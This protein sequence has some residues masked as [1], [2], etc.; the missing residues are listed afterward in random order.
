MTRSSILFLGKKKL[1][2]SA[3]RWDSNEKLSEAVNADAL[4]IG[5]CGLPYIK[6]NKA[7]AIADSGPAVRPTVF[8]VATE[9]Y[10]VS[11]RL[12]LYTPAIPENKYT[13]D[14]IDFAL[15]REG[16][17]LVKKHKFVDLT[18]SA[19]EHRVEV[20]PGS[21]QNYQV[22]YKYLTAIRGAKR[23]STNFRFKGE[24][25]E[26][27]SRAASDVERMVSFL[28]EN[29]MKQVVLAGFSDRKARA[30]RRCRCWRPRWRAGPA[31][32]R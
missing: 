16:Q 11:R 10:P 14:F 13:Q 1:T 8:T 4:A 25:F 26:L 3:K 24:T 12:Y 31:R 30:R 29:G 2:E 18:V 20:A 28:A 9:D 7:L 5:Y 23:L 27:D 32:R 19:Q 15:G 21:N 17:V 22:L 6:Y